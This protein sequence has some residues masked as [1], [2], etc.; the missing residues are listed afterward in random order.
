M[1]L[2]IR[3]IRMKAGMQVPGHLII[4]KVVSEIS[5]MTIKRDEIETAQLSSSD[6]A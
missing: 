2:I 1:H 6:G 4:M 3:K 5:K